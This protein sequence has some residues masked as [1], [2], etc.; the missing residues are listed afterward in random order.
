MQVWPVAAKIPEIDNWLKKNKNNYKTIVYKDWFT[1]F[2][3][4]NQWVCRVRY[5]EEI[6]GLTVSNDMLFYIV[7]GEVVNVADWND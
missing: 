5:D 4:N 3:Q 6:G 2:V 7:S 1:P